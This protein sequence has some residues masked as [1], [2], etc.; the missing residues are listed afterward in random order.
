MAEPVQEEITEFYRSGQHA[1]AFIMQLDFEQGRLRRHQDMALQRLKTATGKNRVPLFA[2]GGFQPIK[3]GRQAADP[4]PG[5]GCSH[6]EAILR[7]KGLAAAPEKPEAP[8]VAALIAYFSGLL[9]AGL[10]KLL[11]RGDFGTLRPVFVSPLPGAETG[12]LPWGLSRVLE[13]ACSQA[14][15]E[16]TYRPLL[17]RGASVAGVQTT[18]N[19]PAQVNSLMPLRDP[20]VRNRFVVLV[21]DVVSSG[22]T[23]RA[24]GEVVNLYNEACARGLALAKTVATVRDQSGAEIL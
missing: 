1:D 17:F 10:A 16:F 15:A 20:A 13:S 18:E 8:E 2:L 3:G 11:T 19:R 24:A 22:Y 6:S 14:G 9:A 7:L 21:D 5:L 4:Q 12:A 23:L